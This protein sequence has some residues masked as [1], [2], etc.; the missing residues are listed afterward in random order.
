MSVLLLLPRSFVTDKKRK[1]ISALIQSSIKVRE[2][3][4]WSTDAHIN[5]YPPFYHV[6]TQGRGSTVTD[7]DPELTSPCVATETEE[8]T[9][10]EE[11]K[12]WGITTQHSEGTEE[13][14][15]IGVSNV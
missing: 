2:I 6:C 4:L 10:R 15:E 5:E 7:S 8:L 11:V 13:Q 12:R 14:S 3:S 1:Y 9:K